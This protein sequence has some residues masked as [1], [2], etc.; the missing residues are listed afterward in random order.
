MNAPTHIDPQ[1]LLQPSGVSL[2]LL[3]YMY[4]LLYESKIFLAFI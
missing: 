4:F 3:I 1:N 2:N